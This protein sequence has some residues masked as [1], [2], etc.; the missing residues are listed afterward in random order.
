[1]DVLVQDI[2]FAL[3]SLR[4]TPGYTAIV[5]AMMALGIGVNTMVFSMVYGV[6]Y[7]PLKL[8]DP[9]S[10]MMVQHTQPKLGSDRQN[11]SYMNFRD[12]R[13]RVASF[14]HVG[15]Y[16]DHNAFV[17][18]DREPERLYA[19]TVTS[20]LFDALGTQPVLG[21]GFTKED[22]VW[23]KNWIPV[24]IS[25]RIWRQ[26]YHADPQA[27]G[28]TLRLNGR[29]RTII[30]VMPPGFQWPEIQDFWIPMGFNPADEH[31]DDY[32]L[33]MVAHLR[34]GATVDKAN[35][36]LK[37]VMTEIDREDPK[38]LDGVSAVA[39]PFRE[40]I[41]DDVR[42]MMILMMTAVGFVLLIACAN[43]ANLMLARSAGRRREISLRL[44]LGA[45][46]G[47]IMRQLLTESVLVAIA[48]AAIGV[49][50]AHWGNKLWIAA[51]PD[52]LP[53]WLD[54]SID[55]PVLLF[56]AGVAVFAGILFGFAPALHAGDNRLS[57]ALREGSAQA[58]TG[59]GRSRM[60]ATLV[61]AEIAFSLVLLVGAGL[62][63][64]TFLA[65][66]RLSSSVV[67]DGVY[68]GSAL[69]PVATYPEP[70]QRRSFFKAAI[71][72][73]QALPGVTS[74]AITLN[75]PMGR[76]NWSRRVLAEGGK[77][78]D[79][80][81][82]PV[83]NFNIVSPDFF[84]TL[85]IPIKRG[86]DINW[87]DGGSAPRIA[88]V[89]ESFAKLLWPDQ[90]AIGRRFRLAGTPDS[91][92][93]CTVVGIVGDVVQSIHETKVKACVY[94]PHQQD[95][96]Q[97]MA[98]LVKSNREP[99]SIAKDMRNIL[100]SMD[101]DQPLVDAYT[102]HEQQQRALWEDRLW[103]SL[104]L[105]FSTLALVIA[106][107]GIYGVMAYSVAQRTQEI[108]I[109]MALGAARSDVVRMV[110]G[111]AMRLTLIGC[112]IGLAAAYAVTRLMASM[113]FGVSTSDPPTFAGVAL[114][115]ALSGII[116]AWVPAQRATRVDPMIA[117][118]CE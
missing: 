100:R 101:A 92:G 89:N 80:E 13:T 35:A 52:E 88:V 72:R 86:R 57:E 94:V 63:I 81:K 30:G 65:R 47:R 54:F 83:T 58:G 23:G 42:P 56:T 59:R 91:V 31:R 64:R 85:G 22:E 102:L 29:V 117:L 14:D 49:L 73:M 71:Q 32:A 79:M 107:V 106:A 18:I 87:D 37:T 34:P 6:M 113:V 20:D 2:R 45:S 116:A 75:M 76:N 95:P 108:G 82:G 99:G 7:R 74:V 97:M 21:H 25:N 26:R 105:T 62:M 38:K 33:N 28:K 61:V 77:E 16:W 114:I 15:A 98:F 68:T 53:M 90:D 69:L 1:M 66:A 12:F 55:T 111:Q 112:G 8:G 19:A 70:E 3:R 103:A 46:R 24:V 50:L 51:L 36:E 39:R 11:V 48:G 44:A 60:R 93:P 4:R 5:I 17:T 43:V 27:L 96:N 109:R 41:V 115:L 104:M 84:R 110:V 40:A 78:Q 67:A 118:R 9:N 10:L